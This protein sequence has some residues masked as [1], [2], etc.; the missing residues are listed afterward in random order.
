M[1]SLS[2]QEKDE[3]IDLTPQQKF[4]NE[5]LEVYDAIFGQIHWRVENLREVCDGFDCVTSEALAV[6]SVEKLEK[7]A[8]DLAFKYND[9]INGAEIL[10]EVESLKLQCSEIVEDVQS[11]SS[12]DILNAIHRSGL[13]EVYPNINIALRLFLTIPVA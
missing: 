8:A 13:Q 9:G 12:I 3:G 6:K 4:C 1:S 7:S 2:A 11:A 5:C 10:S